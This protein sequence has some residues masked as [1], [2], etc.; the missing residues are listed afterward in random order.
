MGTGLSG[1]PTT[2][3]PTVGSEISAQSTSNAWPAPTVIR[4]HRTV[5]CAKGTLAA[6][7][8]FAKEGRKSILFDVWCA[9]R[10]KATIAY[11]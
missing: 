5:R 7:V 4:P 11:Y 1:E 3:A 9:H 10:Q 6:M 2:L 8:D